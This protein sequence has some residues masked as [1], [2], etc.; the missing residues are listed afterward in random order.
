MKNKNLF[1]AIFLTAAII[2][3][4]GCGSKSTPSATIQELDSIVDTYCRYVA[5]GRYAEAYNRC[6][7][8]QY[9]K[10][11]SLKDFTLAHEKRKA[12]PGTLTGRTMTFNRESRNIFTDLREYQ[13]TYE[14]RY[15]SVTRHEHV[16]LNN[17]DGVFLIEG[18]YTASSNKTLRFIVW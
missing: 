14:L 4:G 6:L 10:D 3:F 9:K 12:T 17:E 16:K 13:L 8:S 18:T 7:N 1:Y 5:E 15:G 2:I 11:I